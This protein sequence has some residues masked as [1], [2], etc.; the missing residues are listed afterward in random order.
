[1]LSIERFSNR[2]SNSFLTETVHSKPE[3]ASHHVASATFL[4]KKRYFLGTKETP[5]NVSEKDTPQMYLLLLA[6]ANPCNGEQPG[7]RWTGVFISASH[8]TE[9]AL[10]LHQ[11]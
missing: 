3:S 5:T 1:M 2:Y 4:V 7:A 11:P 8:C 9:S 6:L 10:L